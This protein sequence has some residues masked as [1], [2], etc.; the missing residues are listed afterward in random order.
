M[1]SRSPGC[2]AGPIAGHESNSV[3]VGQSVRAAAA[4]RLRFL[5]ADS[6]T[7]SR[8]AA[9]LFRFKIVEERYPRG[10]L[11]RIHYTPRTG[12]S[13]EAQLDILVPALMK[14]RECDDSLTTLVLLDSLPDILLPALAWAASQKKYNP[15]VAVETLI[16][17]CGG[18]FLERCLGKTRTR[19]LQGRYAKREILS[20]L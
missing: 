10:R 16:K 1:A 11:P 8:A 9:A 7:P 15:R 3:H 12:A 20:G 19:E 4:Q 18:P 5:L 2:A 6:E 13:Y 14:L 17:A